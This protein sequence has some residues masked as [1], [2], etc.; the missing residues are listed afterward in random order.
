MRGGREF[1]CDVTTISFRRIRNTEIYGV[2]VKRALQKTD[3]RSTVK[4]KKTKGRPRQ[5]V[6]RASKKVD[7]TE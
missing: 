5:K 7:G 2:V 6:N 4:M 1:N 3:K